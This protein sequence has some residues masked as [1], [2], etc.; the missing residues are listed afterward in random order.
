MKKIIV[1]LSGGVDSAVA[2]FLLKEAGYDVEAIF[3]KNWNK[4]D[5]CPAEEDYK[6][7][8]MVAETIE[9]PLHSVN[10]AKEY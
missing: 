7:A 8:L 10:F 4:D 9:I 1:G 2:A 6:D 5:D 3:M